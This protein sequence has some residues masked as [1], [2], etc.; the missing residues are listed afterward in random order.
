MP[1]LS[2]YRPERQNDYKFFDRRIYEMF[3]VGGTDIIIHKY[4]GPIDQ[5]ESNDATQPQYSTQSEQNIQDLLFL[6]NRDRKYEKDVYVLRGIYN[7]QDIDF[8][9]TQFGLFL[10]NDTLFL[11]FHLNNMVERI[12]RKLMS[13][14]V[15]ELPHLKDFYPLDETLDASLRRFYVVQEGNRA[16]EGFSPTWYPHLWR[17]KAT[18]LVDSQEY[19]D[20]LGNTDDNNSLKNLL[21]AYK[22]ELEINDAILTQ[23]EE[24]LPTSGYDT[25]GLYIVPTRNDGSPAT[26]QGEDAADTD[27][28]SDGTTLDASQGRET[29]RASITGYLVGTESA[30]NGL[31]VTSG[32]AFPSSPQEGDYVLRLDFKPNRLFRYDGTRWLHIHDDVRANLNPGSSETQKGSF[33]NN[34]NT[35]ELVDGKIINEKQT[36]SNAL[37]AVADDD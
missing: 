35:T 37:R 32:V 31:P 17:V 20:I 13:G 2:L 26:Q 6:E 29:P 33:V 7:V 5:G 16:A 19:K 25:S 18:P 34:T 15:L 21:S 10:Q 27:G 9:L 4:L 3:T 12:G 30:P 23:A 14:D 36:L 28:T 22:K 8:D 24:E 11:T 1:R